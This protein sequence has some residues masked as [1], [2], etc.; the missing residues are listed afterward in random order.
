MLKK[1]TKQQNMYKTYENKFQF[2]HP[3]NRSTLFY[4]Y[5]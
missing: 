3:L 4:E 5:R 1:G 2:Y